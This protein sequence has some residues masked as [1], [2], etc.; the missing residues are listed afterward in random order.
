MVP[1]YFQTQRGSDA[2]G[3]RPIDD[4]G[5]YVWSVTIVWEEAARVRCL[6][7]QLFAGDARA[8]G[9]SAPRRERFADVADAYFSCWGVACA[10][11]VRQRGV[12][13]S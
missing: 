13:V 11:E 4:T 5:R 2:P 10:V 3:T 12:V 8:A 7:R 9:W 1:R 6:R